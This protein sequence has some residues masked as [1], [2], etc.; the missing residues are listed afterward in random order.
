MHRWVLRPDIDYEGTPV[1]A[2][3]FDNLFFPF[4][5]IVLGVI[6]A[7]ALILVEFIM[8]HLVKQQGAPNAS[9]GGKWCP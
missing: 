4:G 7:A 2:L 8:K 5:F 3:G 6:T 1:F 9:K